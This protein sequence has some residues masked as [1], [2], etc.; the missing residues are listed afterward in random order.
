ME[1]GGETPVNFVHCIYEGDDR[2]LHVWRCFFLHHSLPVC[3][4]YTS[5]WIHKSNVIEL[6]SK[7]W[8]EYS[9]TRISR[10]QVD[11]Q[12]YLSYAKI[13]LMRIE[14]NGFGTIVREILSEICEDPTYESPTYARFTVWSILME[15]EQL[16]GKWCLERC[17]IFN[18]LMMSSFWRIFRK[19]LIHMNAKETVAESAVLW[20]KKNHVLIFNQHDAL[21]QCFLK[22]FTMFHPSGQN[23]KVSLLSYIHQ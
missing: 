11:R 4:L 5:H 15:R 9:K 8:N 1:E 20:E 21:H 17:W 12:I 23:R 16:Q 7:E 14:I 10:I 18:K 3:I 6:F 19:H 2:I 13:R 22:I